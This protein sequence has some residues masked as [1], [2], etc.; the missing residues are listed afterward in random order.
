MVEVS[1]GQNELSGRNDTL[2]PLYSKNNL[3]NSETELLGEKRFQDAVDAYN[4]KEYQEALDAFNKFLVSNPNNVSAWFYKGS[5]LNKEEEYP[6]ALGAYDNALCLSNSSS[7]RRKL[8]YNKGII[9]DKTKEYDA[10]IDAYDRSIE[11]DTEN[12]SQKAYYNK[13]N[14]LYETSNYEE[15]VLAYSEAIKLDPNY[16]N[17]IFNQGNAFYMQN[18]YKEAA[19]SYTYAAQLINES[20]RNDTDKFIWNNRGVAQRNLGNFGDSLFSFSSAIKIDKNYTNSL[21]SKALVLAELGRYNESIEFFNR[22]T[23]IDPNNAEAFT[24]KGLAMLSLGRYEEAIESFKKATEANESYEA[25]WRGMGIALEKTNKDVDAL[26]SF[27]RAVYLTGENSSEN[28]YLMG[29]ILYKLNSHSEALKSYK[30][31]REIQLQAY[32]LE[33][34]HIFGLII[35]FNIKHYFFNC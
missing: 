34:F 8:W 30:K 13:G 29:S 7:T 25:A 6:E 10:A 3:N 11:N 5:I 24:G 4:N 14:T 22:T 23:E 9:L 17:A 27:E 32:G 15:A 33:N 16:K 35:F 12:E 19:E 2:N 18:M 20:D 28:L 1:F 21:Y 31:A 26:I